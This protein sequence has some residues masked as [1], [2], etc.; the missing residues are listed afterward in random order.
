MTMATEKKSA[1]E[2]D[3]TVAGAQDIGRHALSF[4]MIF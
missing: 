3:E 4:V 1:V 2:E